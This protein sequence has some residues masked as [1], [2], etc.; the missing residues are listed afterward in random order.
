VRDGNIGAEFA[1]DARRRFVSR[2]VGGIHRDS[3]FLECHPAR[4]TLF[5]ELNITSKRVIDARGSTDFPRRRA[6][7]I[8]FARKHELLDLL[9][10]LVIELVAIVPEKF[11]AIVFVGIVRCR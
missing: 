7:R 6:D 1:Q 9:L 4:E 8:D 10:D 11:D 2:A 3:H 5:G